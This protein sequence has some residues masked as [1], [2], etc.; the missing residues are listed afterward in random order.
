VIETKDLDRIV[1]ADQMFEKVVYNLI[2]NCI[3]HSGGAT[4][5]RVSTRNGADGR[6]E[7]IFEDNG[8]GIAADAK[9]HL[10]EAGYGRNTGYGLF[11]AREVLSITNIAIEENGGKGARF[12]ITVPAGDW[13]AA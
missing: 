13:M 12:V 8:Q 11:L 5:L 1:R 6:L 4:L 3:R 7:I 9:E 10:F 2:D